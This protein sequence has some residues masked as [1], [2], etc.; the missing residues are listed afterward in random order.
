MLDNAGGSGSGSAVGEEETVTDEDEGGVDGEEEYAVAWDALSRG[1]L[2]FVEG[3]TALMLVLHHQ[4][5]VKYAIDV[6]DNGVKVMRTIMEQVPLVIY[7]RPGFST[8]CVKLD[9]AEIKKYPLEIPIPCSK[10]LS[11]HQAEVYHLE[12][13]TWDKETGGT[14]KVVKWWTR[15]TVPYY[16]TKAVL[17]F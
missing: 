3:D 6:Q 8:H 13:T 12:E 4:H 14:K 15:L 1:D 11:S 9:L 7:D 17:E 2:Y 10:V 16:Q 5:G